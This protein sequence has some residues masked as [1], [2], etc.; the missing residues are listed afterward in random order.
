M[1][2]LEIPR[3]LR[4]TGWVTHRK[5]FGLMLRPGKQAV[6]GA[7]HVSQIRVKLCQPKTRTTTLQ[8]DGAIRLSVR[9]VLTKISA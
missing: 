2:R 9:C 7:S 5:V 8:I 4:S 1:A 3:Y 6:K